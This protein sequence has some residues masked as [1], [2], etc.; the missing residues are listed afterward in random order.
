VMG[1]F[2]QLELGPDALNLAGPRS[3]SVLVAR[4]ILDRP[5][6]SNTSSLKTAPK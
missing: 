6:S 3:G 5:S 4:A 2:A 1:A